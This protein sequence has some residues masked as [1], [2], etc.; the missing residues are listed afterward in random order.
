MDHSRP[1]GS[2][3]TEQ[4]LTDAGIR[5]RAPIEPGT[6]VGRYVIQQKLGSGG[7]GSVYAA[8]D[9]ELDRTIA[10]KLLHEARGRQVATETLLHE[11]QTMARFSHP[12]VVTVHDVGTYDGRLFVAMDW[13]RG[14]TLRSWMRGRPWQSVLQAFLQAGEGLAAVHAAGLVHR[15]FKPANVMLHPGGR[16][17]VMDFGLARVADNSDADQSLTPGPSAPTDHDEAGSGGGS[18]QGT[19]AYMAPEQHLAFDID[20]RADQFSFCVS[21]FEGLYGTRP[22]SG[23]TVT[24]LLMRIAN[25]DVVEIPRNGVPVRVQRALIRGLA[26]VPQQRWPT[27]EAL[28]AEFRPRSRG[29]WMLWGA[30]ATALSSFALV[31][32]PT[33]DACQTRGDAVRDLWTNTRRDTVRASL[34][35]S[36]KPF[37][38]DTAARVDATLDAYVE[39]LAETHDQACKTEIDPALLD[40]R[41]ACLRQRSGAL[42]AAMEALSRPSDDGPDYAMQLLGHLPSATSCLDPAALALQADVPGDEVRRSQVQRARDAISRA[43]A[44]DEAGETDTAHTHAK[45][46]LVLARES[47]FSPVEAEALTAWASIQNA[48]GD[49]IAAADA[50]EAAFHTARASHH[51]GEALRAAVELVYVVGYR[52][53][54]PDPAAAWLRHAQALLQRVEGTLA[55]QLHAQLVNNE[56]TLAYS[57]GD[58][59]AAA[60][61]FQRTAE[62]REA[63]PGHES[64]V[65]AAHSNLGLALTRLGRL[66][67]AL[68]HH[69]LARRAWEEGLGEAHPKVAISVHNRALVFEQMRRLDEAAAE[70]ERAIALRVRSQGPEHP[71][72]G[73]SLNNLGHV[74]RDQGRSD[75]A[76][77]LHQRALTV[78][79]DAYGPKHRRVAEA[80]G[81]IAEALVDQGRY[82]EAHRFADRSLSTI[83]SVVGTEHADYGLALATLGKVQLLEGDTT[84]ACISLQRARALLM[85]TVGP[86][87]ELVQIVDADLAQCDA[88]R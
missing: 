46:A 72:V 24:E 36:S 34:Q 9:P 10:V 3:S 61:G 43:R 22:F 18:V 30:G 2:G 40:R 33:A 32:V 73:L 29:T 31:A 23:R 27:M 71:S 78:W 57:A 74:R 15:D 6:R 41:T 59:E 47:S 75:D 39:R 77:A 51:D 81:G 84:N 55:Q 16:V 69:A 14:P 19:P 38:E 85:Q 63:L 42:E 88:T 56:A 82:E 80:L 67:D 60:A 62:L 65:A 4:T 13:V 12:N 26:E 5:Y 7:M 25:G 64:D 45:E 52:L 35:S 48:R 87:D 37:A 79:H 68:E 17:V 58:Y 1:I 44:L 70:Y 8:I 11:A 76:L 21:A 66:E 53:Q 49:Y 86:E 50:F 83:A 28:L 54:Q 20:A